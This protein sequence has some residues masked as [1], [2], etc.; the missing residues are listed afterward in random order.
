MLEAIERYE[1]VLKAQPEDTQALNNLG[2]ALVTVGRH[3][4]AVI[5]LERCLSY[6]S[7]QP[8]ALT[9]LAL[10]YANEGL[11]DR[12]YDLMQRAS[13]LLE[14]DKSK[15]NQRNG[16]FARGLTMMPPMVNSTFEMCRARVELA[17]K[18]RV[19][20]FALREDDFLRSDR[21]IASPVTDVEQVHFYLPYAG[22]NDR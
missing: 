10:H 2:A 11:L 6:D 7:N 8:Q 17:F 5:V 1:R 15:K 9:N 19:A 13:S 21:M 12:S 14:G 3:D 18:V 4:E 22:L 16:L 20:L